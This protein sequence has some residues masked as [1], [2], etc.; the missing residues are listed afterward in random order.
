MSILPIKFLKIKFK[1]ELTLYEKM[2]QFYFQ[3]LNVWQQSRNLV[4]KIYTVIKSFP[5]D[6]KF[7]L[8]NQI[9][10]AAISIP[11]NLSEGLGKRYFKDQARYTSISFGSLMELLNLLIIS[12]DLG[13]IDVKTLEELQTEIESIARQLNALRQSQTKLKPI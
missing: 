10:R 7:V 4:K 2:Y 3:K 6:E 8:T 1:I 5:E 9:K 11:T 12:S 13:Y